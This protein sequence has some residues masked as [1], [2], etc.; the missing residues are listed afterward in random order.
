MAG[1]E[2]GSVEVDGGLAE[3]ETRTLEIVAEQITRAPPPLV[4]PLHW[5]IVTSAP[6]DIVPLAVQV[7]PTR[8]P[9][10]AEPLHWV[11]AA[12][13]VVAG[14]GLQPIVIPPPEP[15]H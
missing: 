11:I 6:E 9:P 8:V 13:E 5:L 3:T 2:L 10:L 14:K 15:T 4:E 1:A 12:P 7:S